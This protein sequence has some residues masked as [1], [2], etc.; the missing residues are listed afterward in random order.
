MWY[1][2][3][4][5]MIGDICISIKFGGQMLTHLLRGVVE[6]FGPRSNYWP[7]ILHIIIII[8]KH[9]WG[10]IVATTPHLL[11]TKYHIFKVQMKEIYLISS[12]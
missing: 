12:I 9:F 6:T 11:Y 3:R 5:G 10:P 8:I 2:V 7:P 1:F 4:C